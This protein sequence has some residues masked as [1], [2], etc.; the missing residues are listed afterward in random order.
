MQTFELLLGD[1]AEIMKTLPDS[2]VDALVTDPPFGI[3][4]EYESGKE[5]TRTPESYWKWLSPIY[6]DALRV[7]KPGGF[8]AIWQTAPYMK[9]YWQWFGND[10]HIYAFCK[11][12]VQLRKTP[13]N[14][15]FDPVVMLYKPGADP[16]RPPRANRNVDF[17]VCDTASIVS[18]P[19]RPERQHPAPRPLD[20][21]S[22]IISNFT[23][24][25][26][27]V[28][29]PFAGSGT[30]GVACAETGRSFIG[31]EIEPKYYAIAESRIALARQQTHLFF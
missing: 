29:D 5:L 15:A 17:Y 16:L 21:V 19:S 11:N 12:F 13:I 2:S 27:T 7:V 25:S 31:I 10:I 30:T 3:G 24:P 23:I 26:G 1:C 20:G 9:H 28:L 18:N 22:E 4:F 14:Y 8:V 6:A